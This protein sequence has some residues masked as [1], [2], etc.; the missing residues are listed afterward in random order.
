MPTGGNV[1][2]LSASDLTVTEQELL[3]SVPAH[4]RRTINP[5]VV[6][7]INNV[8]K[9]PELRENFKE[10]LLSYTH[11]L[12]QGR[13]TIRKYI[14]AIKYISFKLMGYSNV[15]AYAKTFPQKYAKLVAEGTSDKAIS[16]YVHAYNK[17]KLIALIWEQTL[18][19][20]W[21]LNADK[22][23]EAVNVLAVLMHSGKSE[24]TRLDAADRLLTHLKPPEVQKVQMD[25]GLKADSTISEL[26][27]IT[28][29]L[30]QQQK[31]LIQ[32]G[33]RTAKSIAETP[34][35]VKHETVEDIPLD[36]SSEPIELEQ[37]D[38]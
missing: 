4:V 28:L 24:R 9:N 27:E 36:S 3:S 13:F 31:D 32:S 17:S 1:H 15:K 12:S 11:V 30:A 25:I 21:V 10:N 5:E 16:V 19:P 22:A 29:K 7:D 26:K 14:S 18:I 34:L 37:V 35:I 20:T 2:Y 8:L 38:E 23:Q 33:T 6:R